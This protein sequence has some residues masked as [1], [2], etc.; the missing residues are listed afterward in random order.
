MIS[1]DKTHQICNNYGSYK[2]G[3]EAYTISDVITFLLCKHTRTIASSVK[4]LRLCR[5]HTLAL[6]EL[7]RSRVHGARMGNLQRATGA[8]NA[9]P[10]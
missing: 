10:G 8:D 9:E 5:C 6:L 2:H 7:I 4:Q 3:S 1:H